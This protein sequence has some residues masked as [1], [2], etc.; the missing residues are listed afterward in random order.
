VGASR[1]E[2]RHAHFFCGLGG[3][4]R[5]FNRGQARVGNAVAKFRCIGGIDVDPAPASATSSAGRRAG[6]GLDLFSLEQYLAFHGRPAAARLARG[7]ARGRP[8]RL[9]LRAAAHRLPVGALQGLLR[10]AGREAV[11]DRQ[12]PGAQRPDAARHVADVLEAFKDDPP[13]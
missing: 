1:S 5:G 8:P 11:E 13:S 10:P 3:G 4:A 7:D 2:I 12:V 6:H 9:R